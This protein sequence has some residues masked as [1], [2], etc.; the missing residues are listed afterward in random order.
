MKN[1]FLLPP[2]LLY[3]GAILTVLIFYVFP[4]F[5]FIIYPYNL[6]GLVLMGI[7]AGLNILAWKQFIKAKTP[8]RFER[9]NQLVTCGLY[10]Y[11]RNPMYIGGALILLGLVVVFGNVLAFIAPVLFFL[12]IDRIVIPIE[13]EK[14]AQ[15]LGEEYLKYKKKVRRWI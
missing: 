5:N 9:S 11:S 3:V 7:G 1:K 13:E 14:T 10:K 2:N 6:I 4:Q 8:E 15:D 12:A